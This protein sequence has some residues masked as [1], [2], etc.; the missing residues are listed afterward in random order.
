[1]GVGRRTPRLGLCVGRDESRARRA[2]WHRARWSVAMSPADAWTVAD[3]TACP[4][5][6]SDSCEGHPPPAGTPDR[7]RLVFQSAAA[8]IA[9]QPPSEIIEGIAW[10][11]CVTVLASESTAGKT[12]VLLDVAAHVSA[13]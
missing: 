12:F 6:G 7:P 2:L 3:P 11:G 8:M 10:A 1:M 4:V 13:G 5:C 9:S